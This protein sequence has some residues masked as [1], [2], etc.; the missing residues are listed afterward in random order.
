MFHR[1]RNPRMGS[2]PSSVFPATD[3]AIRTTTIGELIASLP[4]SLR[5]VPTRSL[6]LI[7]SAG[8]RPA[9]SVETILCFGIDTAT[10]PAQVAEIVDTQQACAQHHRQVETAAVIV[11]DRPDAAGRAATV[12]ARLREHGLKPAGAWLVPSTTAGAPCRDLLSTRPDTTVTDPNTSELAAHLAFHGRP[13]RRSRD[14]LAALIAPDPDLTDQVAAHADTAAQHYDRLAGAA[15]TP[16][17]L[18]EHLRVTTRW[19]L[20]MITTHRETGLTAHDLAHVAAA[21][22]SDGVRDVIV[23]VIGT[24]YGPPATELWLHLARATTGRHRAT[25]ATL[26]ALDAYQDGDTTLAA[27]LFT[28]A[29][30]ADPRN[31]L[32]LLLDQ[33]LHTGLPPQEVR[34]ILV[35]KLRRNG[36]DLGIDFIA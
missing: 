20:T 26:A 25:A 34:D 10:D 24:A 19:L 4:A 35:P 28:A 31:Q 18:R 23:G 36:T 17:Q 5:S 6:I 32:A 15:F 33:A 30:D 1:W 11:D 22:V 21:L 9:R 14:D 27:V 13:V 16:E 8:T 3:A 7:T 29:L 2:A 12:L